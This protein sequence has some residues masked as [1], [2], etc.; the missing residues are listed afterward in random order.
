MPAATITAYRLTA[1]QWA[2]TALSGEGARRFG[3]RWNSPGTPAVYLAETRALCALEMLVHLS[4]PLSRQK[5]FV[6]LEIVLPASVVSTTPLPLPE[7]WANLPPH[8]N[9][10]RFG[11]EWLGRARTGVLRLPSA[12]IPE[13][14]VLLLN[15]LHPDAAAARIVTT[16]PFQ[17]DDRL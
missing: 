11:D 5:S 12:I 16:R 6:L 10:Q 4:D 2:S 8:R 17:F 9:S 3:G 15:P 1:P 13:E 14:T 7:H